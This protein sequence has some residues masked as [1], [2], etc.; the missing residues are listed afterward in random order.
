MKRKIAILLVICMA[1]TLA[2]TGCKRPKPEEKVEP[3]MLGVEVPEG[4]GI[5]IPTTGSY[6]IDFADLG[7]LKVA[8]AL[9]ERMSNMICCSDRNNNTYA[10]KVLEEPATPDLS[11]ISGGGL[12]IERVTDSNYDLMVT[13]ITWQSSEGSIVET[14]GKT[15]GWIALAEWEGIEKLMQSVITGFSWGGYG[16]NN[17]VK[18]NAI[19][20]DG[21]WDGRI[22]FVKN[23][24][25]EEKE[26]LVGG[27]KRGSYIYTIFSETGG[28]TPTKKVTMMDE[29]FVTISIDA[30]EGKD[31]ELPQ[32]PETIKLMIRDA[33]GD[34]F[35][36]VGGTAIAQ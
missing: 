25:T 5:E 30:E 28:T 29:G 12:Y 14:F 36:S 22:Q 23:K 2:V 27:N 4:S 6:K 11:E 34:W 1:F 32:F 17:N 10:M 19:V 33:N 24:T 15:L 31:V 3:P 26:V 21:N 16:G 7:W 13:G 20:A 9:A 8:P 35:L 18:E